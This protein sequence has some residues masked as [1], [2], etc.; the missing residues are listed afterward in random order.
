MPQQAEPAQPP[1]AAGA[2]MRPPTNP[3]PDYSHSEEHKHFT[4]FT[5]EA[6]V[7]LQDSVYSQV[8]PCSSSPKGDGFARGHHQ[9]AYL[10]SA[11]ISDLHG[12]RAEGHTSFGRGVRFHAPMRRSFC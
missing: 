3:G 4:W 12:D 10:L 1:N 7:V 9:R 6:P 2:V 11:G 8:V 5:D